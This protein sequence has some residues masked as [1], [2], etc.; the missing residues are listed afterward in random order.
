MRFAAD[1]DAF[2]FF[3]VAGDLG[4]EPEMIR[5]FAKKSKMYYK[6]GYSWRV[7]TS[8]RKA[9]TISHDRVAASSS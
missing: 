7:K 3:F 9:S 8:E 2:F 5:D 1:L 6:V 4:P